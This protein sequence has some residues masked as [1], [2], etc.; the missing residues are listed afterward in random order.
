MKGVLLTLGSALPLKV[1]APAGLEN[2]LG[3]GVQKKFSKY[4]MVLKRGE[5]SHFW[6]TT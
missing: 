4:L 2:A 5:P 3:T 1:W 6:T